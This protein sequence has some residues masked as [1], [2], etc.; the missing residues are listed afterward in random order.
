V[1]I[2]T[3]TI[4]Q[5]WDALQPELTGSWDR[6]WARV[7]ELLEPFYEANPAHTPAREK[8]YAALVSYGQSLVRRNRVD[9]GLTQLQVARG[10]KASDDAWVMFRDDFGDPDRPGLPPSAPPGAKFER[11]YDGGHYVIQSVDP[12][13]REVVRAD[14]PGSYQDTS[15]VVLGSLEGDASGR[16]VIV[17]CRSQATSVTQLRFRAE[18]AEQRFALEYWKN[19]QPTTLLAPTRHPAIRPGGEEN[20][21]E[22]TCV[23]SRVI[24]RINGQDIF[25]ETVPD[26]PP[27]GGIWV[28]ASA[29]GYEDTT[30]RL[31][32][33]ELFVRLPQAI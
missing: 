8:L 30:V 10:V 19:G 7:V 16:D 33:R 14:L 12:S 13:L 6:D 2:A 21:L 32:L 11:H 15:V 9:E 22:L 24:G 1:A 23:G 3:P 28:G 5:Q 20:R 17:A 27:N 29:F 26:L 31:S 4:D 18:P 25:D